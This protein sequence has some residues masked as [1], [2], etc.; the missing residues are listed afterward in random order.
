[1]CRVC[2][3]HKKD[4]QR[5]TDE[6]TRRKVIPFELLAKSCANFKFCMIQQLQ[7]RHREQL[8]RAIQKTENKAQA[9]LILKYR[10]QVPQLTKG[11][12]A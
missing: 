1:M 2:T 9:G 10:T 4:T 12:K 5:G 3:V 8:E 7:T 6:K 11:R